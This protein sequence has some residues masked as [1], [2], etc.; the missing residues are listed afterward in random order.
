MNNKDWERY[1]KNFKEKALEFGKSEE[2]I[3]KNLF[4]AHNLIM[5]NMPIVFD[6]KHLGLLIGINY[7]YIYK[8]SNSQKL[9][10]RT[11]HIRKRNGNKRTIH[12]PL[13][14][15]KIIQ[16]W[17]LNNILYNIKISKYA[18]AYVPGLSIKDN[19][20][21]HKKQSIVLKLDIEDFFT[22]I[23]K[24]D[25]Q[26]VFKNAGFTLE[27][28]K[29]LTQ[30]CTIKGFLPQGA[31]TSAYISNIILNNFDD[32]VSEY[33]YENKIRYTRYADDLTFSG[34]FEPKIII[35]FVK[36]QLNELGLK[37]NKNKI[38]VLKRNKSQIVTGIVLNEKIQTQKKFRRKIRLEVYYIKKFGVLNHLEKSNNSLSVEQY[39]KSLK[40]R[41]GYSL[42]INPND[43][44]MKEYQ[45]FI[46]KVSRE[47]SDH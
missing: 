16:K 13:P 36:C 7:E 37:L 20:R 12:E 11:F 21:F 10:Y 4:Y 23:R 32:M 25:V 33:C 44:E 29:L 6:G 19:V 43:S 35:N 17:I 14:N 41:I 28:S 24:S 39:L 9:F 5:N 18:K 40:G 42:F 2:Y 3:D 27:L 1:K 31:S 30:L 45:R 15:L 47:N 26:K 46:D 38:N 34:E 8:V 22:S